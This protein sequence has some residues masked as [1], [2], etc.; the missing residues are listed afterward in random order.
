VGEQASW[1]LYLLRCGD[2]SLYTGIS[3]DVERRLTQHR[4]V[5]KGAK[6]AKSLRGKQPLSLLLQIPVA[7]R[8]E[9]LKLE[10]RIKQLSK[11]EKEALVS[12]RHELLQVLSGQE[13]GVK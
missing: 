11:N 10:Y 13:R 9:A 6:G 5:R 3:T 12:G 8:S 7:N 2:G 4:D 1:F